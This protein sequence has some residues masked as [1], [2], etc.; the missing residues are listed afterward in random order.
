MTRYSASVMPRA[1]IVPS[2]MARLGFFRSPE[3]LTPPG[4]KGGGGRI[5]SVLILPTLPRLQCP[6]PIPR[7]KTIAPPPSVP[8][9]HT[10]RLTHDANT[11]TKKYCKH[12]LEVLNAFRRVRVV[13]R[14]TSLTDWKE[15]ERKGRGRGEEGE[16]RKRK[17]EWRRTK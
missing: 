13:N 10:P 9:G 14:V 3:I 5:T 2:G 1:S 4:G 11:A 17:R 8:E 16:G 6:I 15:G 12:T 7:T